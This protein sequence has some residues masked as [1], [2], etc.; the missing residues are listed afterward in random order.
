[1]YQKIFNRESIEVM[2][3]LK[4]SIP[5]VIQFGVASVMLGSIALIAL[6]LFLNINADP[7]PLPEKDWVKENAA[8]NID[9]L[10]RANARNVQALLIAN[11]KAEQENI[12]NR[13][14]RIKLVVIHE[15]EILNRL[16]YSTEGRLLLGNV[17]R[18][19]GNYLNSLTKSVE[20]VNSG[21]RAQAMVIMNTETLPALHV[22]Q[23]PISKFGQ[24]GTIFLS[25]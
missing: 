11:D 6:V 16:E 19:R 20:L 3:G 8:T 21:Q 18:A 25:P 22:L 5:L 14:D 24:A 13:I 7:E 1:M 17:V 23:E 10:T 15:F 2:H 4:A 12:T 9:S